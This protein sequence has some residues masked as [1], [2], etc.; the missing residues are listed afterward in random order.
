LGKNAPDLIDP[1]TF[2]SNSVRF[3]NKTIYDERLKKET[4][5]V[6]E[7]IKLGGETRKLG[8]KEA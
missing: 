1:K 6:Y 2:S 8:D 5:D 7:K 3:F 4:C